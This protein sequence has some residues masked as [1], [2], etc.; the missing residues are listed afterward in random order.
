MLQL[1]KNQEPRGLVFLVVLL[2]LSR[3]PWLILQIPLPGD[4]NA[5]PEKYPDFILLIISTVLIFIQAI[6]IN[7]IFTQG[8]FTDQRNFVPAAVWI[9]VTLLDKGFMVPGS[10]LLLS[11]IVTGLMYTLMDISQEE[12]SEKQ[13]YNAGFLTG[14]GAAVHPLFFLVFPFTIAALYNLKTYRI[15]SYLIATL[16]LLTPLIWWWSIQYL[17][18]IPLSQWSS[19][20]KML[21]LA[22]IEN[23][24]Y[25]AIGIG[26]IVVLTIGGALSS[27]LITQS[28]GFKRKKNIRTTFILLAGLL[29]VIIL[30]RGWSFSH[31]MMLLP[32]MSIL[33][34]IF[35]LRINKRFIAE[36]VF[37]IFV[38]SFFTIHILSA[39]I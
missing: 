34:S 25:T 30:S 15:K 31:V 38:L 23:N 29:P 14:L 5:L 9:V 26:V 8:N 7:Y 28:A 16:G 1:F 39:I 10:P 35:L 3:L 11:F 37:G 13:A 2:V 17:T 6:W 19:G 27:V 32:P 20:M 36:A 21:G 12:A 22:Y 24:I 18:D 4:I 33:V